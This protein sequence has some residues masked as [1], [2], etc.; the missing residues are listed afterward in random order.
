MPD[1]V[2][3]S[4]LVGLLSNVVTG[5]YS[6]ALPIATVVVSVITYYLYQIQFQKTEK[7]SAK[8]KEC[9]IHMRKTEMDIDDLIENNPTM[10]NKMKIKLQEIRNRGNL[11][12][13]SHEL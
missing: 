2:D 12:L 3:P 10:P 5:Q 7:I 4:T 9:V 11:I 8:Y 6:E 1:P 13:V